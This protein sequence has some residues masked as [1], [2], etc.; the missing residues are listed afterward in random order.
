[1]ITI[2]YDKGIYCNLFSV[3]LAL[4]ACV[5]CKVHVPA[6]SRVTVVPETEHTEPVKGVKLMVKPEVAVGAVIVKLVG[7]AAAV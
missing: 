2:I 1:M 3:S 5:A 7:K 4:P 6:V